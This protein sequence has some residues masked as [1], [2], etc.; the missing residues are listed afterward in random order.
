MGDRNRSISRMSE[1]SVHAEEAEEQVR[2]AKFRRQELWAFK[3]V[4]SPLVV[5][6]MYLLVALI[7][8]PIGVV[9]YIQSTRLMETPRYRYDQFSE[10]ERESGCIMRVKIPRNTTGK[11]FMYYG[12]TNFY[13]NLRRYVKLRSWKQLRGERDASTLGCKCSSSICEHD[14]IDKRTNTA[15]TPCG[16]AAQS[17]F[18]DSFELCY[19]EVCNTRLR[20][21]KNNTAWQIDRD[22]HFQASSQNT[23]EENDIITNEEFMVWMR[24]APYNTFHKLYRRILDPLE[25]D[26]YYVK[27]KSRYPVDSFDGQKFI[28]FAFVLLLV[29]VGIICISLALALLYGVRSRLSPDIANL[30]PPETEVLLYGTVQANSADYSG[31]TR[32]ATSADARA[33]SAA[34]SDAIAEKSQT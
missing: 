14:H 29:G 4:W 34:V 18:N 15:F 6:L 1:L 7:L 24:L 26:T 3:P 13:Q 9:I 11:V 2:C 8:I 27:V 28:Y 31:A 23:Q 19:D 16:L 20:T 10:C 25:N 21:T 12:I 32:G 30:I 17:R 5:T 22:F 33:Q